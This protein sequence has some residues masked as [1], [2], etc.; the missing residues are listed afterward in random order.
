MP[1]E[2]LPLYAAGWSVP[3]G[4]AVAS[5]AM[6]NA[7]SQNAVLS[8]RPDELAG[9]LVA[10]N[11]GPGAAGW[12]PSGVTARVRAGMLSQNNPNVT[13]SVADRFTNDPQTPL[14]PRASTSRIL[15]G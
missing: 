7:A 12:Y 1:R 4:T 13:I 8:D 6:T 11:S 2:S 14:P 9:M 10:T 3:I 5:S 15:M